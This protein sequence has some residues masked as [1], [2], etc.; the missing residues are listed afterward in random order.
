M[1][2]VIIYYEKIVITFKGTK[3]WLNALDFAKSRQYEDA[4][5]TLKKMIEIG[6]NPNIEYCLLRGFIEYA[7]ERNEDSLCTKAIL[8]IVRFQEQANFWG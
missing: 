6:V 3:L 2:F 7:T 8:K 4:K 5:S 1:N